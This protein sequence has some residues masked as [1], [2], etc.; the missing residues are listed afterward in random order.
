MA[1]CVFPAQSRAAESRCSS[2]GLKA[3]TQRFGRRC[4][5]W[6]LLILVLTCIR[7]N[8]NKRKSEGEDMV[9]E[10]QERTEMLWVSAAVATHRS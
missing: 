9:K 7:K 10:S 8:Q 5:A 2:N 4:T 3:V 1:A 6:R